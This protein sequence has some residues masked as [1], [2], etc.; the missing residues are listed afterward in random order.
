MIRRFN[1]FE[2][3]YII[4]AAVRDALLPDLL[5]HMSPDSHGAG[6]SY[7]VTSLY[8]DSQDLACYRAKI[9]GIKF[10]RKVRV[11]IYGDYEA[12]PAAL[13]MLEIKQRINRT[14]Q[15][16]R[17]DMPLSAA[18]GLLAGHGHETFLRPEDETVAA[19]VEYLARTLGLQPTCVITY[20]R[21]AYVGSRYE[22]GLRVTFDGNLAVR[23]PE[24]GLGPGLP[25]HFFLPPD[26]M[27]ME[28]KV[29]ETVPLW[30]SRMIARHECTLRRISKYCRGLALLRGLERGDVLGGE[31]W[32]TS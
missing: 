3:K 32:K 27:I 5:Q 19:E 2:L 26:W 15:K 31:L 29:N 30:V 1:R 18:L 24:F 8:Y 22:S 28:I 25:E 4:P 23:G 10:R 20:L 12:D 9:E 21:Q 14:V 11:R 16:R 13:V 17:V 6:G 7:R